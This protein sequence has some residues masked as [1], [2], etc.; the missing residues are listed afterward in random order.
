MVY[1][2]NKYRGAGHNFKNVYLAINIYIQCSFQFFFFLMKIN[3]N[4][5]V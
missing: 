4:N 2:L 1:S 3:Y 5:E